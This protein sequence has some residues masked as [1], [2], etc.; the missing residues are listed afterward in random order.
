M[1]NQPATATAHQPDP[2]ALAIATWLACGIVLLGLT[3][4]PLHDANLGWSPAFWLLVA[5]GLLL[6]VRRAF[7]QYPR[8]ATCRE[9]GHSSRNGFREKSGH[10]WPVQCSRPR[11]HYRRD[12]IERNGE[13]GRSRNYAATPFRLASIRL[14]NSRM[15][16]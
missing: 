13:R 2:L 8:P 14:S 1:R 11:N 12:G 4:L 9:F 7:A 16:R 5:P 6:I 3:P 10:G 15:I